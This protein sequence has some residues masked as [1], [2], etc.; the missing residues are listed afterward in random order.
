MKIGQACETGHCLHII[1]KIGVTTVNIY[2]PGQSSTSVVIEPKC[3]F[4]GGPTNNVEEH[5]FFS[6]SHDSGR[7]YTNSKTIPFPAHQ[8]C[9][10]SKNRKPVWQIIS[11]F[12]VVVLLYFLAQLPLGAGLSLLLIIGALV[13]GLIGVPFYIVRWRIRVHDIQEKVLYYYETHRR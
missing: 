12:A 9:Y 3:I 5:Y 6:S 4:C 10:E 11:C 13:V 2:P 8:E 1:P 7:V